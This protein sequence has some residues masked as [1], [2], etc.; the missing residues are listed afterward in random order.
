MWEVLNEGGG[1]RIFADKP[2]GTHMTLNQV[3]L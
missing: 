1:C 2:V 3:C